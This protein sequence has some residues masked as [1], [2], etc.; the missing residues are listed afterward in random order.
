MLLIW[1]A[2]LTVCLPKTMFS[3]G[4]NWIDCW[5]YGISWDARFHSHRGCDRCEC[6]YVHRFTCVHGTFYIRFPVV[7]TFCGTLCINFLGINTLKGNYSDWFPP[8]FTLLWNIYFI[9]ALGIHTLMEN[10][11]SKNAKIPIFYGYLPGYLS[12]Q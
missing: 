5:K 2:L 9:Y 6:R 12:L 7:L 11:L 10:V 1:R 8:V 4:Y 3:G